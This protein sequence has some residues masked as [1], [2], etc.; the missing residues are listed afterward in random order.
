LHDDRR[1]NRSLIVALH[2]DHVA[3]TGSGAID[4]NIGAYTENYGHVPHGTFTSVKKDRVGPL[5]DIRDSANIRIQGIT[6][7]NSPGWTCRFYMCDFVHVTGVKMVTDVYGG[8]SDGFDL[9]GCRDVIISDCY[10]ETGDDAIV[11]KTPKGT[12]SCERAAVTNCIIRTSCAAFRLGAESWYAYRNMTFSNSVV[13]QSSRGVDITSQDGAVI[14]NI[15]VTNLVINTNCGLNL[16]R[17][18][19]LELR[20]GRNEWDKNAPLEEQVVGK[21]RNI[22]ISNIVMHTDGR[23]LLTAADGGVLENVTLDNITMHYP[24]IENP[25]DVQLLSDT[26][27]SS[28]YNPQARIAPAAVVVEN[29][30]GFSLTGLKIQWPSEPVPPDYLPKYEHG[31]LV[32]DPKTDP[33]PLPVFHAFW[34]K[35]ITSGLLDIPLATASAAGV[36]AL[37]LSKCTLKVRE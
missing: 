21:M 5:V 4:G 1:G 29:A 10:L 11:F 14:E 8:N 34:G 12:R 2:C 22:T 31:Q 27:Q 13:F 32:T 19:H 28:N 16:T 30:S 7:Q 3:I 23:I 20:K 33:R 17:G 26:N 37:Q 15:A 9:V 35:N 24:W 36:P 18:I 6:L 25:A